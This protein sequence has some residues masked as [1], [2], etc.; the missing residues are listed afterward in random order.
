MGAN[1]SI[2]L[3]GGEGASNKRK[4]TRSQ[5]SDIVA[6]LEKQATALLRKAE[7]LSA[8][9]G[10]GWQQEYSSF[11][12]YHAKPCNVS[13]QQINEG[14]N[15]YRN[16]LAYDDTRVL[17][18]PNEY[19]GNNDYVNANDVPGFGTM[20]YIASQ[21]PVPA[22]FNAFW[23]M[24]WER[25]INIVAMV[26]NEVEGGKLK[27]H[28]YWP[29][30]NSQGVQYGPY[31]VVVVKRKDKSHYIMRRMIL[32]NNDT[33][34]ERHIVHFL[35]TAWPDHG[36]PNT[37]GELLSFR[38]AVN[39]EVCSD[40]PVLIH[41][42]AGVGRTGTY[43]AVDILIRRLEA[44][45][46]SLDPADVLNVLRQRRAF[47]VQTL[48]QYQ[49]VFKAL[50]EAINKRL[51]RAKNALN[52]KGPETREDQLAQMNILEGELAGVNDEFVNIAG[53]DEE[54]ERLLMKEEGIDHTSQ[55]D[56]RH[57][58][59]TDDKDIAGNRS[60]QKRVESIIEY[61]N[62]ESWRANVDDIEGKGY[63]ANVAGVET[64]MTSLAHS[65]HHDAWQKKYTKLSDT[66]HIQQ[67]EGGEEY[68]LKQ[69]L[70]PLESRIISLAQQREAW[71]VKS[72]EARE[73]LERE[74]LEKLDS[75]HNRFNK[76]DECFQTSEERWRER[77]DGLRGEA[78]VEHRRDTEERIGNVTDRLRALASQRN[79]WKSRGSGFRGVLD[80]TPGQV[81]Q[82][83]E[84]EARLKAAKEAKEKKKKEEEEARRAEE[85]RKK[86]EVAPP[87]ELV[88]GADVHVEKKGFKFFSLKK[89][90]PKQ[91][92]AHPMI[93]ALKKDEK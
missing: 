86:N 74:Y 40:A 51:Q 83:K 25:N 23:Q 3:E 20:N 45:S 35:Y 9:G 62:S 42:S 39:K 17:I 5:L 28:R 22:S 85:E 41:C 61:V 52:A 71:V 19:N 13:K 27:C 69:S 91:R 75:L 48:V 12:R 29:D 47:L 53:I 93:A 57:D 49:F 36:V 58:D 15:R 37:A 92:K 59:Q 84:I 82:E 10:V 87:P 7:A 4:F 55:A 78:V 80:K 72:R 16:I 31:Q 67:G 66:W 89:S 26:T 76:L 54:V 46:G 60:R 65:S 43:I 34:E 81:K 2:L 24:I 64:R 73:N 56:A 77:G 44:S 79:A 8:R 18:T 6:Y 14:L 63:K 32:R 11:S 30:D 1:E 88:K 68:D 70:D 38:K 90:K 33:N 21:G 50:L